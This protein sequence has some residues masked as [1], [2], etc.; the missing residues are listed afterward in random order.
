MTVTYQNNNL[1][2]PSAGIIIKTTQDGT[3]HVQHV[4]IDNPDDSTTGALEVIDYAHHE[5]HSG[6]SF[7]YT[8]YAT[9]A[10]SAVQ[11]LLIITPDT[12]KWAHFTGHVQTSGEATV[13]FYE[14]ATVS[15]N[16]TTTTPYNRNRNSATAPTLAIYT[17]PTVTGDGTLLYSG[18]IGSGRSFGGQVREEAEWILKQNTIYLL[19]ITSAVNDNNVTWALNWYEHTNQ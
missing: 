17:G 4:N 19:R 3:A 14:G 12:T 6:S 15:A 18:L 11:N 7:V 10:A 1:A 8:G 5:I 13:A 16:G 9:L 2:T